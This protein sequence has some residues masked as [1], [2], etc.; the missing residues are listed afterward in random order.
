[1]AEALFKGLLTQEN[2]AGK[3]ETGSFGLAASSG[4]P[5]SENAQKA[6][7]EKGGNLAGHRS[8]RAADVVLHAGDIFIGMTPGHVHALK[9]LPARVFCIGEFFPDNLFPREVPDPFCGT[10]S[11]YRAARDAIL[12]AF[13]RLIDF[14]K[15]LD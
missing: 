8:R 14:L 7:E 1:M 11:D 6:V 3:F 13:P 9:T 12:A 2:L 15:N 10:I 5:A 4:I